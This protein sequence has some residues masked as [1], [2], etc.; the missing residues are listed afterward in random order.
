MYGG[1]EGGGG[2]GLG[3]DKFKGIGYKL[4]FEF[5]CIYNIVS[6]SWEISLIL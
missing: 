1:S 6:F 3:L 2:V 5:E 4:L